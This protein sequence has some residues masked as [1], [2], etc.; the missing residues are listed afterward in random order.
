MDIA[1]SLP[2]KA[3]NQPEIKTMKVWAKNEDVARV[4]KHPVGGGIP[5]PEPGDW[6]DDTFTYR[7]V[8]AC[9][10]SLQGPEAQAVEKRPA[11]AAKARE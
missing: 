11:P 3:G 7:Q 1:I 5:F 10:V 9:D 4:L 6:P 8:Q 2:M